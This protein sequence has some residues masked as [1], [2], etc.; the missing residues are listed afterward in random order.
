M[1][2]FFVILMERVGNEAVMASVMQGNLNFPDIFRELEDSC[3]KYMDNFTS[4]TPVSNWLIG[5]ENLMAV[6]QACI[7]AELSRS[8]IEDLFYNNANRLF[9][10]SITRG[11]N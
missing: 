9:S 7:L 6:R 10:N 8:E 2:D 4:K 1:P 3:C 5:L 11:G